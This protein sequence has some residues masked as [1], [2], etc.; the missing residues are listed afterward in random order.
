MYP[1]IFIA[2]NVIALFLLH[3]LSLYLSPDKSLPKSAGPEPNGWQAAQVFAV[4]Q[5]WIL[6]LIS[7]NFH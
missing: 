6:I 7:F 4:L 3:P 2:D 5:L 1:E